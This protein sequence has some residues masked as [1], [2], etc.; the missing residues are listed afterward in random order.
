[1]TTMPRLLLL[2]AAWCCGLTA[3]LAATHPDTTT[4]RMMTFNIHAGHDAS[5]L[6]IALLI[7]Q[8]QPDFVALQEVDCGTHRSHAR[9]QNDRDF[10]TELAY[11]S[12]MMGLYAPTIRFS[13]G[14]YG[15]GLLSRHPY[16][17][18]RNIMLPN[19]NPEM[20]QRALLEATYVLPTGD[21][22]DVACTHLEAFDNDCR[23]AQGE[24]LRQHFAATHHPTLIAGDFNAQPHEAVIAQVMLPEWLDCTDRQPTYSTEKPQE[25]IDYIFARP[26]SRWRLVD[27]QVVNCHLSDH[28]P[29]IATLQLIAE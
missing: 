8:L 7:K 12:G 17:H 5:L 18:S 10:V 14:L 2:L 13:G 22:L 4:V 25:K 3:A 21:T 29:V 24:F 19:P 23:E 20:E 16:C 9:H 26:T 11:H 6:K 28:F 27:T 1:M 15:I